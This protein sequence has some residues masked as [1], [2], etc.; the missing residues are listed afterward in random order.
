MSSG[1]KFRLAGETE[2]GALRAVLRQ[3]SMP[4][5]VSLTFGREPSFFIAEQA[6]S[7]KHQTLIYQDQGSG[8]ITGIGSRSIRRLYVDGIEKTIGYLGS[9]R[10]LTEERSSM[11]LVRGYKFLRTLHGDGEVPYYFTTILDENKYAQ[12]ILESGRAGMPTYIPVG[13]LVTYL[14]P[15]RK[16]VSRKLRQEVLSCDEST[17][18]QA[19]E[20]LNQWNSRY[21]FAPA[22]TLGDISGNTGLLPN[23]SPKDFYVCKKGNEVVGTIGVWDQQSFKQ[24]I[25][26]DYSAKMKVVRPFYNGLAR[27]RGRP[28]LPSVGESIKFVQAPFVSSKD[29]NPEVFESLIDKVCADWSGRGHDYL[30]VGLAEGNKLTETARRLASRELKSKIYLVHWPDEKVDLP[31]NGRLAHV[32]VATL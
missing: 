28:T 10:L 27:L 5:S 8:K 21:Q 24:T 13:I 3:A 23:F 19:H 25:V 1:F 31:K 4:G 14:I 29:G 12:Q 7:M 30:L 15:I 20:C 2:D 22:Y 16:K 17:L 6:G 11:T 18:P 9:L 32:E 26:T